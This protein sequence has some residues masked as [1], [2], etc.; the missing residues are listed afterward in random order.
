MVS[1]FFLPNCDAISLSTTFPYLYHVTTHFTTVWCH[2]TLHHIMVS[3]QYGVTTHF[4]TVWCHHTLHYSMVS[5]HTSPHY[6]VTTHF[7]TLWCHHTLHH[8]MV[9]PHTSP[10][11]GVTTNHLSPSPLFT[12]VSSGC[13]LIIFVWRM[14]HKEGSLVAKLFM[15]LFNVLL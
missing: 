5:P 13:S 8:S 15:F 10:Q 6:G 1:P 12:S 2:H 14:P 4:T 11:Y 7:T 3:P 9:S